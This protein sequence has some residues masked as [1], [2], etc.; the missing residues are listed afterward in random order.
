MIVTKEQIKE[1]AFQKNT[2]LAIIRDSIVKAV[3]LTQLLPLIGS[4]NYD[5]LV[6][7]VAN[8]APLF[9]LVKPYVSFAVKA[10]LIPDNQQ[11]TGTK[12][13]MTAQGSNENS[14]NMQEAK[15]N[16]QSIANDYKQMIKELLESRDEDVEEYDNIVNK[17]II[18]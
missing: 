16:A 9:D 7:D 17:I 6:A 8:D 1:E 10:Y 15:R 18:I 13:T 14:A 11:K 2:D 4:T 3:H 12:G 5:N